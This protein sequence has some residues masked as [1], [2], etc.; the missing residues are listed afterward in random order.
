MVLSVQ[1]RPSCPFNC[2]RVSNP[3]ILSVASVLKPC[4]GSARCALGNG[5]EGKFPRH[6]LE[7]RC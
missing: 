1:G 4:N 7:D 5:D 3:R 2:F 6:V